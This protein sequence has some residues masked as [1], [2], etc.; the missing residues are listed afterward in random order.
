M[1]AAAFDTLTTARK[2]E[3]AGVERRQAEA[4]AEALREAVSA[5]RG[6]LATKVDLETAVA[7]LRGELYRALWIQAGVLIGAQIAI[8][9]FVVHLLSR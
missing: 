3:A 1:Y 6:E 2:L 4:H 8:A 5:D 7:G 9:G